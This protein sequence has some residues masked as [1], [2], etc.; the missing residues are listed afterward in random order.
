MRA[1]DRACIPQSWVISVGAARRDYIFQSSQMCVPD[2]SRTR[3][4]SLDVYVYSRSRHNI[5]A[6]LVHCDSMFAELR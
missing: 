5:G 2:L 6:S 3:Q 4:R 1:C